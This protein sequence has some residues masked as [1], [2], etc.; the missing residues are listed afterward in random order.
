[1][2]SE[3]LYLQAW[4]CIKNLISRYLFCFLQNFPEFG[5]LPAFFQRL[6]PYNFFFLGLGPYTDVSGARALHGFFPGAQALH[7]FCPGIGP[8]TDFFLGLL[9]QPSLLV[10][11]PPLE[12]SAA[13][14]FQTYNCFRHL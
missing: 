9:P 6:G 12:N 5:N 4:S 10:I 2:G 3:I 13:P 1:M 11:N 7:R 8:Y 14:H